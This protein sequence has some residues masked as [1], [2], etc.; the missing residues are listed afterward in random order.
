MLETSKHVSLLGSNRKLKHDIDDFFDMV[1]DST[2]LFGILL[3]SYLREGKPTDVFFES[4]EALKLL[5]VR[6]DTLRRGIKSKLYEKTLI[7]DFRRDVLVM[8]DGI[9]D[10]INTQESLG[11]GLSVERPY[12]P[13]ELH[14]GLISLQE[15]VSS[16][17]NYVVKAARAFFRDIDAVRD[18]CHKVIFF[19][20]EADK[21]A[22]R[23]HAMAFQHDL[24]LS[25]KIH[26]R[27][28]V[29]YIDGVADLAEDISES[30]TIYAIKRA[31]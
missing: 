9:D 25:Q 3:K 5:E 30:V 15:H 2:D 1:G 8:L 17:V 14:V 27:D 29:R 26:I 19:E 21:Q 24:P 4:L 12:F 13:D 7:P 18:H 6:A 16:C 10:L 31:M 28:F 11:Y 23:L 22:A 20:S